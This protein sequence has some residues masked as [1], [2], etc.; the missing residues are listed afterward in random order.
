MLFIW[1]VYESN[2]PGRYL[3]GMYMNLIS[4]DV[5]HKC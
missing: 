4:P 2:K 1:Y 5:K 3:F